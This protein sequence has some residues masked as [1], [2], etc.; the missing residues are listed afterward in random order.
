LPAGLLRAGRESQLRQVL[1][2]EAGHVRQGDGWG[3]LLFCLALPLLYFHPFY[4]WLRRTSDLARELVVDD[5]AATADGKDTYASE[6]LSLARSR[7]DAGV[8]NFAGAIGMLRRRSHFYRRMRML[9][10]RSDSLATNCSKPWRTAM[11]CVALAAVGGAAAL[12]GVRPALAQLPPPAQPPVAQDAAPP[13][14]AKLQ[15]P[16]ADRQAVAEGRKQL[17]LLQARQVELIAQLKAAQ[18]ELQAVRTELKQREIAAAKGKSEPG[19]PRAPRPADATV[20]TPKPEP[21][22]GTVTSIGGVQLDLVNLANSIVDASGAYKQAKITFDE[23]ERMKNT[24]AITQS[25]V[26]EATARL[27]TAEKRVTLLRAIAQSALESAKKN[28]SLAKREY[29]AG[30]T[31]YER[32]EE[33]TGKVKMLELILKGAE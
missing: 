27:E 7:I 23:R 9:L 2:H 15:D 1:L 20:A 12:V 32:V 11:T 21:S 6:L 4:W 25:E 28:F 8:G 30:M 10:Q 18:Y 33:L 3:N 24:G 5:W 17:D 26:R 31:G 22:G 19:D 29:E 14:D 16:L 13:T